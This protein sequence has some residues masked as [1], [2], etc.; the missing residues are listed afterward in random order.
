MVSRRRYLANRGYLMYPDYEEPMQLRRISQC[1]IRKGHTC[2]K[3]LGMSTS[4]FIACP[5][6]AEVKIL[7]DLISEKLTRNKI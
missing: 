2:G 7:T 3:Y 4:C 5:S 6:T 1:F